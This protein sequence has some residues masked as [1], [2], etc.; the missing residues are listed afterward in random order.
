MPVIFQ[1]FFICVTPT[2]LRDDS[3]SV[4]PPCFHSL[5][6]QCRLLSISNS[7]R[8][9]FGRP[10]LNLKQA[11]GPAVIRHRYPYLVPYSVA[12]RRLYTEVVMTST[13]REYCWLRDAGWPLMCRAARLLAYEQRG[14]AAIIVSRS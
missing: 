1:L 3:G 14:P 12:R 7:L 5:L 6:C 8:D 10:I 2:P 11:T 4:F 13:A 9:F